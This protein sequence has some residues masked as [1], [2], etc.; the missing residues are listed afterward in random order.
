[1]LLAPDCALAV[2]ESILTIN[3][4][5]VEYTLWDIQILNATHRAVMKHQKHRKCSS[6]EHS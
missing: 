4:M 6:K 3:H 1:M 2:L 5:Q